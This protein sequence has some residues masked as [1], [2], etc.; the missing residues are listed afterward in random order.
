MG[1]SK[2]TR[3]S[4]RTSSN[5]VPLRTRKPPTRP[6]T[7]P[8]PDAPASQE[9]E[10]AL[11][12]MAA[13]V[14]D[15]SSVADGERGQ[16]SLILD[17]LRARAAFVSHFDPVRDQ[18]LVMSVRGRSDDRIAAAS[19]GEGPVGRA[20]SENEVVREGALVCA[21]LVA[22]QKVVGC[23]SIVEPKLAVSDGQMK[24]L[25]AH[26]AAAREVGRLHEE[27][28]RR[29]RDLETAVAGL[30]TVEKSREE[31]LSNVSHDLK[32]PLATIK[33]YLTMMERGR[34]GDLTE[35]QGHAV[36]VCQRNSDR[37]TR[38]INDLVLLSRLRAGDMRLDDKPFGLK[39]LCEQVVHGAAGLA[40]QGQLEV[41]LRGGEVFVRGDR[42]RISEALTHAVEDA[43]FATPAG[44][45]VK[46][47]VSSDDTGQARVSV[48]DQ[49]PAIPEAELEHLFDSYSRT[50]G[51][52]RSGLGLPV[53][54]KIVRLHGGQIVARTAPPPPVQTSPARQAPVRLAD[55]TTI[56]LY[57][58]MYAGAV[59]P[60][61]LAQAPRSGGILLVEDDADCREVLHDV[62]EEE[63]Y[64]VMS[65]A[66]AA[67]ARSVLTNIRPALIFLDIHLQDEDGRAV[68]RFVRE[69][70]A[71][72]DV[73]VFIISG[74]SD[75][76]SLVSAKGPERVEG[77]LEKPI[78]LSRF[79]DTVAS[80]VRPRHPAPAA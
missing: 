9:V 25:A 4:R 30:K 16:L 1:D 40:Q 39:S 47:E 15:A 43:L 66:T 55:A 24:M 74:D 22:R 13:R 53:A 41:D 44:G 42:D 6:T 8:P 35:K 64:R 48:T 23:L 17:L 34:L 58:P 76:G 29:T 5:V 49:G 75:L 26:L 54:A 62:L 78:Q 11:A 12:Q 51:R 71:L 57:L 3:G 37:L 56:D 28:I 33:A 69:T 80:V 61:E 27:T 50:P 14:S 2:R 63:G 72:A 45:T 65:T 38:L 79:L 7:R 36:E 70:P 77:F 31:L 18:L 67:E 68:L 20:Y 19:P 59:T 60:T 73:P 21:P 32:N 46:V 10:L 52:R